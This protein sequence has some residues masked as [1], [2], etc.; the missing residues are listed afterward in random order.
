MSRAEL[1]A[2]RFV[3]LESGARVLDLASGLAASFSTRE[4]DPSAHSSVIA[5]FAVEDAGTLVLDYG[6]WNGRTF[7]VRAPTPRDSWWASSRAG[8]EPALDG[9]TSVVARFDAVPEDAVVDIGL[10]VSP[11]AWPEAARHLARALRLAG[12]MPVCPRALRRPEVS[13]RWLRTRKVVLLEDWTSEPARDAALC[14]LVW[15]CGR[16]VRA[17]GVVN[18]GRPFGVPLEGTRSLGT[19][20]DVSGRGTSSMVAE[21]RP[22]R[23]AWR[24][25]SPV[26][27]QGSEAAGGASDLWRDEACATSADIRRRQA[28]ANGIARRHGAAAA[29]TAWVGVASLDLR[30]ADLRGAAR[31]SVLALDAGRF[32]LETVAAAACVAAERA[33]ECLRDTI[34]RRAATAALLAARA[35]NDV[36]LCGCAE[37]LLAEGLALA[38][39]VDEAEAVVVRSAAPGRFAVRRRVVLAEA[40]LAR[41]DLVQACRWLEELGDRDRRSDA[42]VAVA[43]ARVRARLGDREAHHRHLARARRAAARRGTPRLLGAVESAEREGRRRFGGA[44]RRAGGPSLPPTIGEPTVVTQH[45]IEVLRLCQSCPDEQEALERSCTH[46]KDVLRAAWVAVTTGAGPQAAIV[47]SGRWS[48]ASEVGARAMALAGAIPPS[49]TPAGVEAATAIRFGGRAI[50]ALVVAWASGPHLSGATVAEILDAVA[51]AIAP[52]VRVFLERE[53]GRRRLAASPLGLVGTSVA[54]ERVR[55]A[56][57]RAAPAPFPVLVLGESGSGKELVARAMHAASGRRQRRFCAV[58]CAALTDELFDAE[59]FG[60]ARGAF[61]GALAE[62]AGLFEEADGGTLFLDEVGE[63]TP[64]GQAKLLRVLQEREVRRVGE[65]LP[66]RVDVRIVAATNRD[67]EGDARDGRFRRDLLYRL[68]VLR[69]VLPPLR[70]RPEDVPALA[71][72]FWEDAAARVGSR[73]TLSAEALAALARYD[74]PGNVRELQNVISALAVRAPRRG[75]TAPSA[76]PP[77]IGSNVS[78]SAPTL[79]AARRQFETEF[80]RQA[81]ARAGGSHREA[82]AALG[83]SRQGL[84]KLVSRLGL[85]RSDHAR[86]RESVDADPRP[87]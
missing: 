57:A 41:D 72:R 54:I 19:P 24:L 8:R 75:S 46:V 38:G 29:A 62:R 85:G 63:L 34:A 44:A 10:D 80:V 23:R 70:A 51:V 15:L 45:V 21:L 33:V 83:V 27:R 48:A 52:A 78:R 71:L 16:G 49:P 31:T 58:N 6:P 26:A 47:A 77:P 60:H 5:P 50:A 86:S 84:A 14:A 42:F 1:V 79:G 55:E 25:T 37:T 17:A 11:A 66:R 32:E 73:A 35:L 59:L 69:V 67:L 81:L 20:I 36:A 22:P 82:A 2:D 13:L 76:L 30:R 7:D 43:W 64:R 87:C 40:A 74:W 65:N 9:L 18:R 53:D 61:T 4:H 28:W 68:D 12:L 3:R 39:R 56:I